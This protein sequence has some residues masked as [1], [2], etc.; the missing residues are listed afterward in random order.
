MLGKLCSFRTLEFHQAGAVRVNLYVNTI[1]MQSPASSSGVI[2]KLAAKVLSGPANQTSLLT[3]GPGKIQKL[4][5]HFRE[6]S[7][8]SKTK[9]FHTCLSSVPPQ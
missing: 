3:Q 7:A 5:Q 1:K 6:V 2:G 4:E 9:L 8:C